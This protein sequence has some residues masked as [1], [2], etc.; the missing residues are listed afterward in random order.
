MLPEAIAAQVTGLCNVPLA[1]P[2]PPRT[3]MLLQRRGAYQS[4]A[5]QALK[6]VILREAGRWIDQR[7][8]LGWSR[9]QV[10]KAHRCISYR[11]HTSTRLYRW[12]LE[13][14]GN[15]ACTV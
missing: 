5:T 12:Q 2:P 1:P 14:D 11:H 7:C 3:V 9:G 10:R 4:A 13:K 6:D 15:A 8:L